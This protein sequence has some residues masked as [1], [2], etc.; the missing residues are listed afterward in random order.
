MERIEKLNELIIHLY[1][2]YTT[3]TFNPK[4]DFQKMMMSDIIKHEAGEFLDIYDLNDIE[5][6]FIKLQV[7]LIEK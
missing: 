1:N 5:I 3:Q 4:G 6:N 2:T 7:N